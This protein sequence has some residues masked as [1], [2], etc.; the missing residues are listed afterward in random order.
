MAL[1]PYSTTRFDW[2]APKFS[3]SLNR[4]SLSDCSQIFF[5]TPHRAK[6]ILSWENLVFDIFVATTSSQ[7]I[8]QGLLG[9]IRAFSKVLPQIAADF[10]SLC[11][12]YSVVNIYQGGDQG[13]M[14]VGEPVVSIILL[15]RQTLDYSYR[16]EIS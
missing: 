1:C 15:A 12:K 2:Y 7:S 11:T 16:G 3:R 6:D 13:S 10:N 9:S 4:P 5:G 14:S 8:V